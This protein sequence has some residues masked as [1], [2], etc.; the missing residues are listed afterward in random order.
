MIKIL[1]YHFFYLSYYYKGD[2]MYKKMNLDY[3]LND[4]EPYISY[5]TLDIHY[6]VLYERYLNNLNNLLKKNNFNFN[7]PKEEIYNIIKRF[8]VDDREAIL[9][10]LGGVI[11]HEL[12]FSNM[13]PLGKEDIRFNNV[14][15]S[16]YITFQNFIEKFSVKAKEIRGS[17]YTFLVI[18]KDGEL[19]LINLANQDSP[20]R[21]GLFPIMNIDI[22]EHSYFLDYK[23]NKDGYI[24]NYFKILDYSKIYKRYEE[25]I[26]EI[27]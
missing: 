7:I 24:S 27:C 12:Y 11:N 5:E 16:K 10:N 22:W 8:P 14:I 15:E 26:K 1:W 4:L 6:N 21:M 3:N 25:F 19:G 20:Y 2:F 18:D 23:A 17:G 9:F 13:T